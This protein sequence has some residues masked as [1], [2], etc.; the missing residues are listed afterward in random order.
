MILTRMKETAEAYFGH[1]VTHA[2]VTVPACALWQVYNF[3]SNS[4]L[5]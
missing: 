4:E 2:I 3:S 5:S 1:G